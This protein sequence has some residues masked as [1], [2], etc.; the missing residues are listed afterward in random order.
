M[1][2]TNNFKLRKYTIIG[3]NSTGRSLC[4]KLDKMGHDVIGMAINDKEFE[5]TN[6]ISSVQ[7]VQ[8][9]NVPLKNLRFLKKAEAVIVILEEGISKKSKSIISKILSKIRTKKILIHSGDEM[10]SDILKILNVED[11][12]LDEETKHFILKSFHY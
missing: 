11:V 1:A 9:K 3:M 2:D 4:I 5:L 8:L 7:I 6:D 10:T 12:S